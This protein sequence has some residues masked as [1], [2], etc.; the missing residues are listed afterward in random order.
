VKK[1]F[2]SAGTDYNTTQESNRL[3]PH[4]R[5]QERALK[6]FVDVWIRMEVIS[7]PD[8]NRQAIILH[9]PAEGR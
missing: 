4:P 1:C 2:R 7:R 8:R 6:A 5:R 3:T 9:V